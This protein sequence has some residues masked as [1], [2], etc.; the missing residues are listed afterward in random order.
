MWKSDR[1][2][3]TR[4]VTYNLKSFL[5]EFIL[6]LCQKLLSRYFYIPNPVS[7]LLCQFVKITSTNSIDKIESSHEHIGSSTPRDFNFLWQHDTTRGFQS[8]IVK[9]FIS[10]NTCM[11]LIFSAM[12]IAS[13]YQHQVRK[14]YGPFVF[15]SIKSRFCPPQNRTLCHFQVERMIEIYFS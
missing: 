1:A 4:I 8:I 6:S 13:V 15:I 10:S 11:G 9:L 14:P 12:V 7:K 2:S 3:K 5:T